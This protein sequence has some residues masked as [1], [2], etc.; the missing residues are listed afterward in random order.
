[1]CELIQKINEW[2]SEN[3]FTNI[4]TLITVLLSGVISLIIS[5]VYFHKGNRN[6]LKMSVIFP[7]MALLK[8]E[9]SRDNYRALYKLTSDYNSRYL[10]KAERKTIVNLANKYQ[11]I[12][13]YNDVEVKAD[14]LY[15]YFLYTLRKQGI[16]TKCVPI[17]IDGELIDYDYPS[18]LNYLTFDLR[19][20]LE[21]YDVEYETEQ[22]QNIAIWLFNQYCKK[23]YFRRT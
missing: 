19:K 3:L 20:N 1:M 5:A 11:D 6:N 4:F 15:S 22:C 10:H 23:Y 12:S 13:S 7:I 21:K 18:D 2:F 9:Y 16:K 8:E 14:C 17:E